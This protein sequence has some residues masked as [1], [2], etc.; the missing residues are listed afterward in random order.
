MTVKEKTAAISLLANVVL[1]IL[2]FAAFLFTGSMAILAEA[3]HSFSDI[4]TS[5]L[6][7]VSVRKKPAVPQQEEKGKSKLPA[8]E[9]EISLAIGLFMLF[10]SIVLLSKLI[11]RQA[12]EIQNPLFSG[13]VF[14]LFAASSHLVYRYEV[15]VGQR[16][17]SIG[18][19]ADG[20]HSKSDM[21]NS[22]LIGFTLII[23]KINPKLI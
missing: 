8:L 17:N 21:I 13:I 22:L 1:T 3:W 19:I 15:S 14:L 5:A 12:P 10:V 6:V 11:T 7:L 2:K 16:E 18:L 9:Y 20:M 4:T 23:Y